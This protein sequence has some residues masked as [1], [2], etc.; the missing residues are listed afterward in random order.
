MK[1]N[2]RKAKQNKINFNVQKMWKCFVVAVQFQLGT[3][4][5]VCS[6]LRFVHSDFWREPNE[7]THLYFYT[8]F[9]SLF[10]THTLTQFF[11]VPFFAHHFRILRSK[12]VNCSLLLLE[13]HS[14]QL[15]RECTPTN[16]C[17]KTA[18]RTIKL[19]ETHTNTRQVASNII[20]T[21]CF[22]W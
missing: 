14:F 19:V 12:H 5:R 10:Y 4:L 16:D 7:Y 17:F 3:V 22:S 6:L 18:T 8:F 9:S 11:M 13:I 20:K 15:G 21:D 1:W 2:K